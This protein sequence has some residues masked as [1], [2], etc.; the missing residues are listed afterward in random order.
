MDVGLAMHGPRVWCADV[1]PGRAKWSWRKLTA[2]ALASQAQRLLA[3][4]NAQE[5]LRNGSRLVVNHGQRHLTL[6]LRVADWV[7][8]KGGDDAEQLCVDALRSV[9]CRDVAYRDPD[10]EF[11]ERVVPSAFHCFQPATCADASHKG[12]AW[13][14]TVVARRVGSAPCQFVV[15][16]LLVVPGDSGCVWCARNEPIHD[17][18]AHAPVDA[19]VSNAALAVDA[20]WWQRALRMAARVDAE[21]IAI[22]FD[23][24]ESAIAGDRGALECHGHL[25]VQPSRAFVRRVT[26]KRD[27]AW[28]ALWGRDAS[29]P[30][31]DEQDL[32]EAEQLLRNAVCCCDDNDDRSDSAVVQVATPTRKHRRV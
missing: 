1:A 24:W 26:A 9:Y 6:C 8:W 30:N 13:C 18:V 11:K 15:D 20:A 28:R 7:A 27:P 25:H 17:L 3:W 29:P 31:Y 2:K 21:L 23:G 12:V 10:P 5:G 19:H 16:P 4:R 22:N 32:H 14:R